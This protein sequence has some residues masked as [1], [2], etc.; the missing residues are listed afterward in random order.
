MMGKLAHCL[1]VL[2]RPRLP[3]S[4]GTIPEALAQVQVAVNDVARSVVGHR[5]EGHIT[6]VD[7]LEAAK[8]LS[9]NQQVVRATAMSAWSS[10]SS[11]NGLN[12]TQNPVGSWMFGS[13]DLTAP[14]RPSRA[15]TAGEVR[16]RTRGIVD[17]H[18]THGLEVWNG[19]VALRNAKSKA[20]ASR[21]AMQLARD[22]PL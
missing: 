13:V 16:V 17:T 20:K 14:A 7:L 19:C 4:S 11:S 18:M 6:I 3:G 1:P 5:R 15:A 12:G 2:A 8:Y 22:S 9:L 10:Y 21:A